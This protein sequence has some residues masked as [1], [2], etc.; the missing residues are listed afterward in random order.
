MEF[1]SLA[2]WPA[3]RES[4]NVAGKT[5]QPTCLAL[6]ATEPELSLPADDPGS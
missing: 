2:I 4:K 3:E 5:E 6:L 1:C